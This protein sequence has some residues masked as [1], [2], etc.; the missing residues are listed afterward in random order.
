MRT[1]VVWTVTLSDEF[2]DVFTHPSPPGCIG[3]GYSH[4]RAKRKIK[5]WR[6]KS[7]GSGLVGTESQVKHESG[8]ADL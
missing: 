3:L 5:E 6:L 2:G 4:C 8:F 1:P 7:M